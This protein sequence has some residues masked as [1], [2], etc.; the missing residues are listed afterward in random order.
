MVVGIEDRKMSVSITLTLKH[1]RL[2]NAKTDNYSEYIRML[3][4][5]DAGIEGD[6]K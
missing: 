6:G 3:I 4:C 2:L 5:K 1:I